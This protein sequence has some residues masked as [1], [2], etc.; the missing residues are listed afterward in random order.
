MDHLTA[1]VLL[2]GVVLVWVFLAYAG[3]TNL[4]SRLRKRRSSGRSDKSAPRR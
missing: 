2:A 4:L 1:Y 3:Y